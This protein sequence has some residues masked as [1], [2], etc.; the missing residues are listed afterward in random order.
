MNKRCPHGNRTHEFIIKV[1]RSPETA[2]L[3][4]IRQSYGRINKY[5]C[6]RH[7]LIKRRR[8]NNGLESRTGLSAG[9]C[10]AVEFTLIE[11]TAADH[12]A[13]GA[14][15]HVHAEK[16]TLHETGLIFFSLFQFL[17]APFHGFAGVFLRGQIH[18]RIDGET[19]LI[20]NVRAV[21]FLHITANVFHKVSG[22]LVF[23]FDRP[24][25]QRS[26][27]RLFHFFL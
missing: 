25:F 5:G 22:N 21:F 1:F 2:F 8:V 19:F 17:Q 27:G 24:Q 14:C 7:A 16:R 9:L 10:R 11:I 6:R 13:N 26:S 20:Q 12:R 18:R 23:R 3:R 4:R 15:S